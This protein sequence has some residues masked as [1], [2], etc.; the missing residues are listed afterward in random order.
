MAAGACALRCPSPN[1]R[2]A[3]LAAL[4][5]AQEVEADLRLP[6][7][8]IGISGGTALVGNIGTEAL[9]R[10][11]V[12]GPL[13]NQALLLERLNRLLDTT[14]LVPK[15]AIADVA[16]DFQLEY[17]ERFLRCPPLLETSV[18]WL[19][20]PLRRTLLSSTAIPLPHM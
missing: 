16:D 4:A 12:V 7:I 20:A 15:F 11:S 1:T 14:I 19:D 8:S 9:K 17:R 13:V 18:S 5:A 10:F 2:R 3:L 6:A